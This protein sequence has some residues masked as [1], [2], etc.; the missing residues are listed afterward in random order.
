MGKIEDIFFYTC[1]RAHRLRYLALDLRPGAHAELAHLQAT[2][3]IPRD[4]RGHYFH[5]HH[6]SNID[7]TQV[8]VYARAGEKSIGFVLH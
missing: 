7:G 2:S 3:A 4:Q 6:N 1:A 5:K 8:K